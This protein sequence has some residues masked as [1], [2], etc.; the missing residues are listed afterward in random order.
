MELDVTSSS[1]DNC[2]DLM[3]NS[4]SEAVHMVIVDKEL[5][6]AVGMLTLVDNEPWNLSIR[7]ENI[8]ITP[9]FQGTKR[10]HRAMLLVVS[11]LFSVGYRRVSSTLNERHVIGRRFL[12][13]CGM[14]CEATLRKHKVGIILDHEAAHYLYMFD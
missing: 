8:W 6:R 5:Q 11:H 13:R 7:I 2:F 4:P 12:E 10:A 14:R 9:A 1:T 3:Y